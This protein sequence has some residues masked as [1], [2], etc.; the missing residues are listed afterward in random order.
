MSKLEELTVGA[1]VSGLRPNE[2]VTVVAAKWHGSDTL[3]LTFK[4]ESGNV[5]N[6]VLFRDA[7]ARLDVSEQ[8]RP[9]SFDAPPD[10]FKLALEAYRISLWL[11]YTSPSP[12]D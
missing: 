2:K 5:G 6:E 4:D 7:E 10:K 12:R 1:A 3:D 8:T 9:W 11:L